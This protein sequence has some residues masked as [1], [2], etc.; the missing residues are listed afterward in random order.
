MKHH[1]S[2]AFCASFVGVAFGAV[3]ITEPAF[4]DVFFALNS[5]GG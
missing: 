3:A 4:N 5:S 1:I 2:M